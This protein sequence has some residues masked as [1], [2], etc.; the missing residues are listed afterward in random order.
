MSSRP[1]SSFSVYRTLPAIG[2]P[3]PREPDL[4][5]HNNIP[6]DSGDRHDP[7]SYPHH[8]Q[9]HFSESEGLPPNANQTNHSRSS[10]HRIPSAVS[11]IS[12]IS[13]KPSSR[14][15]TDD[16]VAAQMI[17]RLDLSQLNR[18]ESARR[19]KSSNHSNSSPSHKIKSTSQLSSSGFDSGEL[20]DGDDDDSD[21]SHNLGSDKGDI[22]SGPP[23]P[24]FTQKQPVIIPSENGPTSADPEQNILLAIRLPTDGS[25]HQRYFHRQ[26]TLQAVVEFAEEQGG[27]DFAG[28]AL[29]SSAPKTMYEDLE[30]TIGDAGLEDR[31]V[32]HLEE[33]D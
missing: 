16:T 31:T 33:I 18:A 23:P 9:N 3:T 22:Y 29:V 15:K 6:K 12:V 25:R 2:T 26:D 32:L 28:Y 8:H 7:T 21:S 24:Q 11:D 17:E 5:H 27:Q 30:Q 14:R 19:R 13:S 10:S 4:L 20:Y 1:S